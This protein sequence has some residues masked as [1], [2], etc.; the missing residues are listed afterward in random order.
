MLPEPAES[1]ALRDLQRTRRPQKPSFWVA[2]AAA[3]IGVVFICSKLASARNTEMLVWLLLGAAAGFGIGAIIVWVYGASNAGRLR[4]VRARF[5]EAV[6]FPIVVSADLARRLD[7][8]SEARGQPTSLLKPTTYATVAADSG[9]MRFLTGG[10]FG[11]PDATIASA[12]VVGVEFGSSL[13]GVR[14]M[15]SIDLIVDVGGSRTR[16]PIVP[17]R[18][19]GNWLRRVPDAEM[20][21]LRD[22]LRR[23]VLP[24]FDT[25]SQL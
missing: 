18:E 7:T 3:V 15:S 12:H 25:G 10:A 13:V 9:A 24:A 21:L 23:R 6:V 1:E 11:E 2:V 4:T 19:R 16:L 20:V 14:T 5:P 8:V 22:H 17:M